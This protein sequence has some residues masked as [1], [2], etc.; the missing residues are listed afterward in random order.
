MKRGYI[1]VSTTGQDLRVQRSKV[2]QA[3]AEII[4]SEK[5]SGTTTNGRTELTK[6][7]EDIQQG[8]EVI[9]YKIDR[10]A[11]SI[12]DLKNIII[13]INQAGA[14]I[15]FLDNNL[16]FTPDSNNPMNELMLNMLASFAQFERDLIVS[17]TQ[18]GKEYAKAT[19][20]NYKEGRPKR[21]IKDNPKYVH[22]LHLMETHSKA[23]TAKITGI[24]TATLGRI[25]RQY[26][27]EQGQ[28]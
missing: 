17:R 12:M 23:E 16:T 19:N 1:R 7:L 13:Q 20:P 24:S 27:E 3:G 10:L 15:T 28:A 6:L 21:N 4:Y 18:E 22:A 11:R 14:I 25:K 9:V 5:R 8:D 26:K 2:K